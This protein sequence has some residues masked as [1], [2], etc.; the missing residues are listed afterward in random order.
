MTDK[1]VITKSPYLQCAHCGCEFLATFRQ[2]KRSRS[3]GYSGKSYCSDI[4]R[5]AVTP[6][7]PRK[8]RFPG[9][10]ATCG[11][12]FQSRYPGRIY[13]SMK[14]YVKSPQFIEMAKKNVKKANAASVLKST[15]ELPKPKVQIICLHCGTPRIV[16]PS[17]SDKKYC[18]KRCYRKYMAERFDRWIAAPQDIALPQGYDEFLS[19]E[20]LPCL[21][22]GC[23]WVGRHLGSHVNLAHGIPVE[24]FKRAAGFNLGSGLVT[25]AVA[26]ALSARPHIHGHMFYGE[27]YLGP[28][29]PALTRG[30]A[31]LEGRE[32]GMKARAIMAADTVFPPRTCIGCGQEYQPGTLNFCGKYC[33]VEC[34]EVTYQRYR[35]TLKFWMPCGNCQKDFQGSIDQQHRF[36]RGLQVFCCIHCRQ[37]HNGKASGIAHHQRYL[38]RLAVEILPAHTAQQGD[39]HDQD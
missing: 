31:S 8:D 38:N 14:C 3:S 21:V 16:K 32:H 27:R 11:E 12:T 37:I 36:E 19:Q 26:E 29:A 2:L 6:P 5:I 23:N 15:G 18:S 20:E 4:C 33:S 39:G 7:K 9:T 28:P 24:E 10:C 30:Y 1:P 17:E 35:K 22:G 13:C 34:R 25:P